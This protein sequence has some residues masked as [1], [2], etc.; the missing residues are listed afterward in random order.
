MGEAL[1]VDTTP[2]NNASAV[3]ISTKELDALPDDPDELQAD[4][5]ALAGPSAGPNG[6]QMYIDGF[7]AGQLPPKS[8]IREIRINSNP[9]SAEF[10]QVGFGRIEIFTKA[11]GQA[12]HGSVSVNANQAAFNSR[13]PFAASQ[14]NFQSTQYNA[15]VG[16]GLGKKASL[17]FNADY[18]KIDNSSVINAVILD[19]NFNPENYQALDPL[20]Q[21][22][23]NIG[24]RFDWQVSNNN[25]LSIR[26]Q[27]LRNVTTNNGVGNLNLPTLGSNQLQTED[28]VQVTDSQ[29]FGTKV[30]YETRFQYLRQ[31]NSTLASNLIP[32]INVPGSFLGGGGGDNIDLQNHYEL[33]SYTS[34]AFVKHFLKFGARIRENTDSNNSNAAFFG[35]FQFASLTAYQTMVR[36]LAS[37]MGMAAIVVQPGCNTGVVTVSNGQCGPTQYSITAGNPSLPISIRWTRAHLSRMTGRYAP[38]SR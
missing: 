24:P 27:F 32:S 5:E 22:R 30:V 7:T 23:L 20:P 9:F 21:S 4:L 29:Y 11:G 35:A 13:N 25:T 12:W 15:N 1:T 34:I 14:G 18:R 10:D 38:T 2:A 28:Q 8:S 19:P 36:G 37:G 26:Y 16:G 3:V 33:Q 6:G 17:F 31:D